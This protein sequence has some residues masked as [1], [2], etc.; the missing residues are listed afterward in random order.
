M[1]VFIHSWSLAAYIAEEFGF[2]EDPTI[3]KSMSRRLSSENVSMIVLVT[4]SLVDIIMLGNVRI[5]DDL[6]VRLVCVIGTVM[7]NVLEQ[8]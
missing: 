2:R 4:R 6:E 8:F 7:V 5:I 1:E 3:G